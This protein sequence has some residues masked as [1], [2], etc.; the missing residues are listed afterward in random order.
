M[1]DLK[2]RNVLKKLIYV[3]TI[4]MAVIGVLFIPQIIFSRVKLSKTIEQKQSIEIAKT[5]LVSEESLVASKKVT[6]R[7]G[8]EVRKT[9]K[10]IK[11]NLN[12]RILGDD[13]NG[14]KAPLWL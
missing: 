8:E 14:D 13:D 2:S 7:N 12:E 3:I 5:K 4:S 10:S 9:T 1:I 11:E 6:S